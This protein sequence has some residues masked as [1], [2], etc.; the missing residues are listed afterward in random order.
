MRK[1]W[2]SVMAA[3]AALGAPLGQG[4]EELLPWLTDFQ[5]AK[6]AA[7]ATHRVILAD[8]S[9]SDWCVWCK[10]L[11]AEVFSKP[12]FKTFAT[13]NLVLFLADFPQRTELPDKTARQNRMLASMFGIEGFPTVLLLDAA[14]KELARTGYEPG[15]AKAYVERLQKLM[16]STGKT[17][18]KPAETK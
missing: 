10:R 16:P 8:F 4:G 11:D 14:G 5:A 15:G 7:T 18:E 1:F 3:M 12:E 6:E 17:P 9:G 2:M 13:N